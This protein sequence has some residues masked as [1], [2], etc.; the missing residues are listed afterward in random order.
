[1]TDCRSVASGTTDWSGDRIKAALDWLANSVDTKVLVISCTVL[2][3]IHYLCYDNARHLIHYRDIS[4]LQADVTASH[5]SKFDNVSATV[6]IPRR[7]YF[8]IAVRRPPQ[9]RARLRP[10]PD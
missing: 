1:M 3:S 10:A 2:R 5:P 9:G 6:P 7:E 8:A 4:K